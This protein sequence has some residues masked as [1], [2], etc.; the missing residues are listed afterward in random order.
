MILE[1]RRD[2]SPFTPGQRNV[3]EQRLGVQNKRSSREDMAVSVV[4]HP[5]SFQRGDWNTK[6]SR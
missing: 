5:S 1:V 3:A 4:Y 2:M 6:I